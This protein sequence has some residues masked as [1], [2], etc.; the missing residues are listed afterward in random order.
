MHD[1]KSVLMG[2]DREIRLPVVE[3]L[4]VANRVLPSHYNSPDPLFEVRRA[5]MG[6]VHWGL[7]ALNLRLTEEAARRSNRG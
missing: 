3:V 5:I 6:P 4:A 1:L 2:L 7:L